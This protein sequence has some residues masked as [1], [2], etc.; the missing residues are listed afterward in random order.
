[1]QLDV[2][3]QTLTD[4]ERDHIDERKFVEQRFATRD[5][6]SLLVSEEEAERR[7]QARSQMQQVM[8]DLTKRLQEA[9]ERKTLAEAY[10]NVTQ[11]NKNSASADAAQANTVLD[12]LEAGANDDDGSKAKKSGTGK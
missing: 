2:L 5:M 8:A 9:E 7:K 10:K 12:L 11:G 4:E 6:C 3:A 1:M